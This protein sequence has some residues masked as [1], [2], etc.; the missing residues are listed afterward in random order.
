VAGDTYAIIKGRFENGNTRLLK[1]EWTN[2][3]SSF[4]RIPFDEVVFELE[5]QYNVKIILKRVN[6]NRLFSGGFTH[7][8]LDE[9]LISITQPMNLSYELNSSNRTVIYG[10]DK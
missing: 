9:A 7:D 2:N 5:R 1:P 3:I 8:N 6:V 10:Q 4:D